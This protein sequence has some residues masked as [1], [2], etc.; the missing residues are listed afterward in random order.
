MPENYRIDD[1]S[2]EEWNL[3]VYSIRQNN[4]ILM[5]G[6]GAAISQD[7]EENRPLT[8]I[9]AEKHMPSATPGAWFLF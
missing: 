2:D 6:P 9:L 7:D 3:L 8:H 1:W 5:L 4:C